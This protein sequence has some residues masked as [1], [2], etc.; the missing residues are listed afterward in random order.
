M[1]NNSK[2]TTFK[3]LVAWQEGHKLVL[4]IY[5][6]TDDFP[7]KE[8][9]SLID[10]MRRAAISITSNIAE[11]FSRRGP[12]DKVKFYY[13]AQGSLT[14]IQNQ[15]IVAK[16]IHYLTLKSFNE[17]WEQSVIAHKLINGII[18]G[19]FNINS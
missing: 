19:A 7:A 8:T 12:K 16:D 9:Y 18:K 15:I 10:Q 11:G 17:M 3:D 1:Y 13:M 5:K 6:A 14:E 2:I 4:L